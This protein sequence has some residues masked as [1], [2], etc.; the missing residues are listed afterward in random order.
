MEQE[1]QARKGNIDEYGENPYFEKR[2]QQGD[3]NIVLLGTRH[4]SDEKD[5]EKDLAFYKNVDPEVL[6]HEGNDIHDVFREVFPSLTE[7]EILKLDPAV[8][9]KN[10]E[11][12]FLAWQAWKDGKI[13][14][15]WDLPF[16]SQIEI[17]AKNHAPDAVVGFLVS[18]ALSKLYENNTSPSQ[19]SIS[20]VFLRVLSANDREALTE[21]GIDL[22]FPSLES[23]AQKYLKTSF[24]SLAERFA[25][26]T[27]RKQD[28]GMF[29][30]HFDPAYPGETN[31][32]LRDMNVVRDQH[33]ID[34][35]QRAK[36]AYKNILVI[37]G[38]SHV[39]TW[40]PAVAELYRDS[41]EFALENS[42]VEIGVFED[43]PE[44]IAQQ[45][46]RRAQDQ[47]LAQEVANRLK[48]D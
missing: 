38:G 46:T 34:V 26:E 45:E 10:Q 33:A 39:R 35:M 14:Q 31:A 15:T 11:Q 5:I 48:A 47:S 16:K 23:A 41:A 24:S 13:V 21:V 37:A 12:I 3:R 6:I 17:V 9:A 7:D 20:E 44:K 40:G 2:F 22:S 29:H 42:G 28:D 19:K 27:L 8:V 25:D 32:V 36:S 1:V 30:G 43:S 4:S 18:I